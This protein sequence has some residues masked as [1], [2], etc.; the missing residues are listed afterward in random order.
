MSSPL[1][2]MVKVHV[3]EIPQS[4]L[5]KAFEGH[6][7][8]LTNAD[9][10]GDRVMLVHPHTAKILNSARNQNKG[11]NVHFTPAE[12][13]SDLAYHKNVGEGMHGGSLWSWLRDK[14]YPWIKKNWGII[15][16]VVSSV[17][18]V[19]LPALGT[20]FGAPEAGVLARQGLKTLTGVGMGKSRMKKGSEEAREHMAK[21]RAMRTGK[22]KS[23]HMDGSSF[24]M[25]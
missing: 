18:D 22:K 10:S 1:F 4:K 25:P 2:G 9:L 5:K 11:A 20:A 14:A 15:K 23:S 17:A 12:A 7:I 8:R 6:A 13:I 24:T 19:A 16:P 3:G 21:L